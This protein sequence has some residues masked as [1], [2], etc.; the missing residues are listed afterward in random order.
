MNIRGARHSLSMALL[1]TEPSVVAV[2]LTEFDGES[3]LTVLLD[4]P[5]NEEIPNEYEGFRVHVVESGAFY[6][7]ATEGEAREVA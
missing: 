2:G 6:G 3:A 7:G 4:G 5:A 1:S